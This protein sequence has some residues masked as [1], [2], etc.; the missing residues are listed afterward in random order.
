VTCTF[1]GATQVAILDLRKEDAEKAGKEMVAKFGER[2]HL[3]T[4]ILN[5]LM[6]FFALPSEESGEF[7]KNQLQVLPVG[8]DVSSEESVEQAFAEIKQKFG[9]IDVSGVLRRKNVGG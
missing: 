9:K 3:K 8:C 6:L 7:P 1:R 4:P 5:W 2:P